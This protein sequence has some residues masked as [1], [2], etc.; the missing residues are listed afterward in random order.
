MVNVRM[1]NGAMK[2]NP[3]IKRTTRA[4]P[5]SDLILSKNSIQRSILSPLYSHFHMDLGMMFIVENL[6]V[7][8]VEI[9]NTINLPFD[10]K[11]R[12]RVGLTFQLKKTSLKIHR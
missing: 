2:I 10:F 1:Y 4:Q 8:I 7:S 5:K 6:K 3:N 11:S 12:E 9:L